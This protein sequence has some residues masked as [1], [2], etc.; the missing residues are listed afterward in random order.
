MVD[1]KFNPNFWTNLQSTKLI[2]YIGFENFTFSRNVEL[3]VA[4]DLTRRNK[5]VINNV[6]NIFYFTIKSV[7]KL[8]T[9][10]VLLKKLLIN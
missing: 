3:T 8:I 2:K 9:I 1:C 6:K 5:E 7:M 10:R 4:L